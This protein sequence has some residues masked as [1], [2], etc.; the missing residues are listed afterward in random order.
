MF[1]ENDADVLIPDGTDEVVYSDITIAD[2][3]T[4]ASVD[5]QVN[6]THSYIGDLIIEITSPEGTTVRLHNRNGGASA[7]IVGWYDSEL[8]VDGPGAL[9]DFA[10][11]STLGEWELWVSDNAG[12]DVGTVNEWCVQALGGG[13][14]R[15][16]AAGPSS[17]PVR[18]LRRASATSATPS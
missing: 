11:E 9:A 8:S 2:D 17:L 1:G 10:G 14:R 5:V 4:L 12:A 16:A 3:I 6:I 18:G 15:A 13:G 7:N